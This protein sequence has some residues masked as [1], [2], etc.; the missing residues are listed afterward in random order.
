MRLPWLAHDEAPVPYITIPQYQFNTTK[1]HYN[2]I[3]AYAPDP[4]WMMIK[5]QVSLLSRHRLQLKAFDCVAEYLQADLEDPLYVS[6][7]KGFMK[8]LGQ[9]PN[10]IWKPNKALSSMVGL[11]PAGFGSIRYY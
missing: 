7:P 10:K 3:D 6:P 8:E 5:L 11:H 1:Q 2:Q 4:T 9:G